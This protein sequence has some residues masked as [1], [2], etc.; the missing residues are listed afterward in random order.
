V[1]VAEEAVALYRELAAA[2]PDRYRPGLAAAL[3]NLGI[4]LFALNRPDEAVP[5]AEE[6]VALY[7]ELAAADPDRYRPGLAAELDDLANRL[8]AADRPDDALSVA[9]EAVALYQEL[10]A[11]DPDRYRRNRRVA[12]SVDNLLER[13]NALDRPDA[14]PV[15]EA[16]LAL[17]QDLP[18]VW[19]PLK[20]KEPDEWLPPAVKKE[21]P[22][23]PGQPVG[24]PQVSV[25][26]QAVAYDDLVRSAFAELVQPGRLLFNPPDR[27]QLGGIE[28]IEVRLARALTLDAELLKD[29]R[30]PVNLSWK[31]SRPHR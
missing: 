12:G 24:S 1:P 7:R 25:P 2:D 30:G 8:F 26:Q 11:A 16:A 5:V 17:R 19:R 18:D 14:V 29:L 13:L 9:Q 10:A 27:M 23:A 4:R 31:R 28:R 22:T 21:V 6:A 3:D 20:V 15:I